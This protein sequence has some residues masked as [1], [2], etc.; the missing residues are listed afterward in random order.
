MTS[1]LVIKGLLV[2][3][4][5]VPMASTLYTQIFVR[6]YL[7]TP[8]LSFLSSAMIS[9]STSF[10]LFFIKKKDRNKQEYYFEL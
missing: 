7:A 9:E 8:S 6:I 3:K 4:D 2:T 10:T 1:R 5:S